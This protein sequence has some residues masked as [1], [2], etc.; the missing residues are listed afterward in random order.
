MSEK[1]WHLKRCSLFERLTPDELS[2]LESSA[3]MRRFMRKSLVY[4][5]ADQANAVLLLVS[6]QIKICNISSDGK[7]SILTFIE[8]GEIFGE[9]AL[10]D[11]DGEREEY[12]AALETSDVVLI[13][14]DVVQRLM[15]RHA[16]VAMEVTQ[17]LGLRRKR[18]ERRLKYLMFR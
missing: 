5:P 15:Q 11:G 9:L 13:P 2:E 16:H 8:P 4:L 18:I 10:L 14:H 3:R 7:E 6:G 17:L 1:I 12:A